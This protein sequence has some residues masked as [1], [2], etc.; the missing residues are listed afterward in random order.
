MRC[1]LSL[2][3]MIVAMAALAHSNRVAFATEPTDE[4]SPDRTSGESPATQTGEG[5]HLANERMILPGDVD[6]W[7]GSTIV[8]G[9]KGLFKLSPDG[10]RLL[11]YR[12]GQMDVSGHNERVFRLVLRDLTDGS[13]TILPVPAYPE[14]VINYHPM[15]S[16]ST[17]PFDKTGNK[18]VLGVGIDADENGVFDNR[19]EKMRAVVFDSATST[20]TSLSVTAAV[21]VASYNHTGDRYIVS[22]FDRGEPEEIRLLFS[23]TDPISW[24]QHV[25]AGAPRAI[26]PNADLLMLVK[27]RDTDYVPSDLVLYDIKKKQETVT[28]PTYKLQGGM[29][30]LVHIFSPQWTTSGGHLHYIDIV[31]SANPGNG[32]KV[33]DQNS[34]AVIKKM[35]NVLPVG[36]GPTASS[37]V[38]M[39]VDVDVVKVMGIVVHEAS[40]NQTWEIPLHDARIH[41]THGGSVIYTRKDGAGKEAVYMAEIVLPKGA[42]RSTK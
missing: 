31:V 1:N 14:R 17:N 18:V 16:F 4:N 2:I 34:K 19:N 7:K 41:G 21:V 13:E 30:L 10:K 36:P 37:M 26:S 9:Q 20:T 40:S 32:T 29:T 23:D 25:L 35:A 8:D 38:L 28:L 3:M 24:Q 27:T 6:A 12:P 5:A 22:S 11:Y 33:W 15:M 42:R 39:R